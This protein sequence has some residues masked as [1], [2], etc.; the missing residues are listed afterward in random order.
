MPY[1]LP[2]EDFIVEKLQENYPEIDVRH[3]TAFR[4]MLIT[5][6]SIIMQ[7]YRD[8]LNVLKRNQSLQNY[9]LMLED[10]MDMLVSNI[11]LERRTGSKSSGT[12][13]IYTDEPQDVT[14]TTDAVFTT[15]DGLIFKPIKNY[16]ITAEEIELNSDGLLYYYDIQVEAEN[17]GTVYNVPA[18]TVIYA[19]NIPTGIIRVNN[20]SGMSQ[21]VD[22]DTNEELYSI[23]KE[24]ITVRDLVTKKG[25]QSVLLQ[26]LQT[27]EEM[28]VVGFGDPE[29][30]RDIGDF[31]VA[32]ADVVAMQD[33][34]EVNKDNI[35]GVLT[36]T[37]KNFYDLY[38]SPGHSLI[39]MDGL[40]KGQYSV[41]KV[42][43][44]KLTV[45]GQ[46]SETR[47]SV[48]RIVDEVAT[49][50]T[51]NESGNDGWRV[52]VDGTGTGA[53]EGHNNKIAVWDD[54][55]GSWSFELPIV[56]PVSGV[57]NAIVERYADEVASAPT[58]NESGNDGWRV[59][60][61]GDVFSGANGATDSTGKVFTDTFV[62][63]VAGG[64]EAGQYLII[65]NLGVE[66]DSVD[67]ATQLTLKSPGFDPGLSGLS[68]DIKGGSGDFQGKS[69]Q[70][71]IW[72]TSTGSWSYEL[73]QDGVQYFIDGPD[74]SG[75]DNDVATWD[76]D[77][78][79]W[80]YE[81]PY[82]GYSV[83]I[84]G[85]G[86]NA[87]SGHDNEIA[88]WDTSG[89]SWNFTSAGDGD[90]YFTN[91]IY[92]AKYDNR[93]AVFGGTVW[94]FKD[95]SRNW[96]V[97]VMNASGAPLHQ[98]DIAVW[99]ENA[100][101][102]YLT[103]DEDWQ[104][105][106][107]N[108]TTGYVYQSSTW[109]VDS[110]VEPVEYRVGGVSE[111]EKIHMGGKV[112]IYVNSASL[113]NLQ[114]TILSAPRD[115]RVNTT[116]RSGDISVGESKL[117]DLK[118]S[119]LSRGITTDDKIVILNGVYQGTYDIV[120]IA[121]DW[122]DIE[123]EDG[124]PVDIT[125]SESGVWYYILRDY[126]EDESVWSLPVVEL[127]SVQAIDPVTREVLADLEVGEDYQILVDDPTVRYSTNDNFIIRLLQTDPLED[128][129]YIG[130]TIQINYIHDPTV[131]SVQA[132]V[133]NEI[134]RVLTADLLAK[135]AIPTFVDIEMT[136]QGDLDEDAV[137]D[138]L[139][140][141]INELKF[142][143]TLKS[144][145]LIQYLQFFNVTYVKDSSTSIN[146]KSY[147]RDTDGSTIYQE[148][149]DYIKIPRTSLFIP[150]NFTLTKFDDQ[151]EVNP[152]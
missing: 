72:S 120:S 130:S 35:P 56:D 118:N 128:N 17:L 89:P 41:T 70:I 42:E 135:T 79:I 65:D 149:T 30:I 43:Q 71:A 142:D 37:T 62:D 8:T 98:D 61:D 60:I 137:E 95:P 68:Y 14:I 123:T 19:T 45:D 52:L 106:D 91:G 151:F 94:T 18:D 23:A 4:D 116:Y 83:I 59:M 55:G 147:T 141:Y 7:P 136:Y 129:Y 2:I 113:T 64:V 25:I 28:F 119:F 50:P 132:Y 122:V 107:K 100:E 32:L 1:K 115:I 86:V 63:F 97:L 34:G 66:V 134:N 53:F 38:V 126:Y 69:G 146:M 74:T 75:H 150:R 31:T 36:D 102:F 109:N 11:F 82:D 121:R 125:S 92:V 114:Q 152:S 33:S 73:P 145:D 99:N 51:G 13:R 96:K 127:E 85:E 148:S 6:L 110:N 44:T 24:S 139:T 138:A 80:W 76:N 133:D 93:I 88:E 54:G 20:P 77:N 58:G 15:Q 101:W 5:P 78:N 16:Y 87:F 143:A 48:E 105:Y 140:I 49:S 111:R 104:M 47:V 3:G 21:G 112:D 12:E 39:I 103:P 40:D 131:S 67:S 10:E 81:T 57:V 108:T 26:N 84:K 9:S 90:E 117:Y 46:F 144:S 22:T 124:D 27:I 29:M